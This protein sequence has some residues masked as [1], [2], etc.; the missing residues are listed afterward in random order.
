MPSIPYWPRLLL[1]PSYS[2]CAYSVSENDIM[3]HLDIMLG[4]IDSM[5]GVTCVQARTY[6]VQYSQDD[7][8]LIKA[9]VLPCC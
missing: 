8:F 9:T 6:F 1:A 7:S 3:S 5:Y 4:L 2:A